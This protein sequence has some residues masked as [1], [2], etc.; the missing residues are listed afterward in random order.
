MT[1]TWLRQRR[2]RRRG[3]VSWK[4]GRWWRRSARA[5][6]GCLWVGAGAWVGVGGWGGGGRCTGG[7]A[8][9]TAA[10]CEGGGG[11]LNGCGWV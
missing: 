7:G 4:L 8:Q 6:G 3:R 2:R 5:R 11:E 9:C 10:G 1:G